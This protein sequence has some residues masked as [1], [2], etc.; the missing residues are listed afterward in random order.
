VSKIP[1]KNG[2]FFIYFLYFREKVPSTVR[3]KVKLSYEKCKKTAKKIILA[4]YVF[5]VSAPRTYVSAPSTGVSAPRTV[6]SAPET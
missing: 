4:P 2:F 3:S 5:Y 1:R 6:V